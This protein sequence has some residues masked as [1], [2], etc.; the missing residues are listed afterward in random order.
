MCLSTVSHTK[1]RPT[2]YG[3]KCVWLVIPKHKKRGQR[4][5]YR[6]MFY[7]I[8]KCY[9]VGRWQKAICT[10]RVEADESRQRYNSGFHV[11]TTKAAAMQYKRD[12]PSPCNSL[13]RVV[14]VK[15]RKA[16]AQGL[17]DGHLVI[18][19]QEMKILG[20]EL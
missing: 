20:W 14:R 8:K 10:R 13:L 15:Y 17:Q 6:S 12:H 4:R 7:A 9:K 16:T 11:L 1:P 2:G 5:T 18:V 3:W 19:A